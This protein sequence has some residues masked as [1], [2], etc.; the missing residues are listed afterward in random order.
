[1]QLC[2]LEPG[3]AGTISSVTADLGAAKRLADLGFVQGANLEMLCAGNPCIVRVEDARVG[4]GHAHQACIDL[5][6]R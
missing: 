4:L 3:Q 6:L 1:V 5:T 2:A